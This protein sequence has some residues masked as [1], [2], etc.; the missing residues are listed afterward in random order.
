LSPA[1]GFTCRRTDNGAATCAVGDAEGCGAGQNREKIT[2]KRRITKPR[3]EARQ[4]GKVEASVSTLQQQLP[5]FGEIARP[6]A[7]STHDDRIALRISASLDVGD[8][9]WREQKC[10]S[11][12]IHRLAC[13]HA[14]GH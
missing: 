10:A 6:Q 7:Q 4:A 3:T 2:R 8:R 1:H 14:L 5:K 11:Q 12:F 13:D 9:E